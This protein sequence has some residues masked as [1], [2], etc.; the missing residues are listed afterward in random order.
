MTSLK[1]L[2]GL[3][4]KTAD[5]EATRAALETEYAEFKAFLKSKE[6]KEYLD[7]EKIV[8]TDDFEQRKK[9]IMSQKYSGTE[10]FKKEKE[11]L[12]L[13][14]DKEIKNFFR[15]NSSAEL[16]NLEEF[17]KSKELKKFQ[18]L[19]KF[20]ESD[21]YIAVKKYMALPP[22]KKYEQSDL[23]KTEQQY[24][25]QAA[26]SWIK[27]YYKVLKNKSFVDYKNLLDS[28]RIKAFE[29]LEKFIGS[30][31]VSQARQNLSKTEFHESDEYRKQLEFNQMLKSKE[32]KNYNKILKLPYYNDYVKLDN[33]DE[34]EA[35]EELQ[36][37]VLSNDFKQE[38]KKI[39]SAKFNDTE[40][41]R[42]QQEY[43]SLKNSKLFKDNFRFRASKQYRSFLAIKDSEKLNQHEE[44]Q[45]LMNSAEFKKV[46]EYMLLPGSKKYELSDE[47]KQEQRFLALKNSDQ[48]KWYFSVRNSNKFDFLKQWKISFED[49]FTSDKLDR[50]KWI[51]RYFWGDTILHDSYSPAY[52]KQFFTDGKNIEIND[53]VLK[54]VTKSEKIEGKAWNPKIGFFPREFE[55]TSG[56]ISTGNSFRQ[57][58]GTF[59]AKIK[60]N[61]NYPVNHAFWMLADQIV[62]HIEVAKTHKRL[63][64]SNIW[65]NLAETKGIKSKVSKI[66][67]SRFT[68]DYYIYTLE[69]SKE[70]LTW[71]INSLTV[72]TSTEGVP[73]VPMYVILSSTL[74][75]NINGSVLPASMEVDWVRCYER[76]DQ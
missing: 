46:K 55:Y 34:I 40:E 9:Q 3:F 24:H 63:V 15:I 64:M 12:K 51:T 52:E 35:F 69:W 48:F 76:A 10:E 49:D 11:Y 29:K 37:H 41:Y 72:A 47:Y 19:E 53:S 28:D 44:L 36:K 68:S 7:L 6:L 66:G 21:E 75:K 65:G 1:V 26:S 54:I 73:Q 67:L 61:K 39:E 13:S 33:S 16:K 2:L 18:Q 71:K 56:L 50:K 17:E 42:K 60:F 38:K 74:Y 59:E 25:Q 22:K 23:H 30:G 62:P 57:L 43:L 4:P 5:I 70:R 32:I 14:K 31:K 8:N 58:Y 45:A 27:N 20:L